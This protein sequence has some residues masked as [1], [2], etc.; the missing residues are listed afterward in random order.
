MEKNLR[1]QYDAIIIGAGAAGLFCAYQAAK[2]GL[3]VM[4]L[5][6]NQKIGRK[7]K[8]SGGG[9]CNFTNIHASAENYLCASPH[10]VKPALKNY[11]PHDFIK[12]VK[13]HN[14]DFYE[15]ELGQI[16]TTDGSQQI[17]D[18]L[19][20]LCRTLGVDMQNPMQVANVEYTDKQYCLYYYNKVSRQKYSTQTPHLVIA[21]GGLSFKKLGASGLGYEIAK[22]FGHHITPLAPA[23]VGLKLSDDFS[24]LSGISL[25]AKIQCGKMEFTHQI[26]FTHFGLSGPAILQISNYWYAGQSITID[27]LPNGSLTDIIQ[28]ARTQNPKM[29][30]VN[31]LTMH[32]PKKFVLHICTDLPF[33]QNNIA[34]LSK[35]QISLLQSRI[36]S[37]VF[38]PTATAGYD[39]AEVT[40]GGVDIIQIN[41]KSMESKIQ[42]GLFFIGEVVDVT[43]WLGGYNF[44]WAW[45][46]ATLAAMNIQGKIA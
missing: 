31:L 45:S 28:T 12:L 44:Q 41:P 20:K 11:T 21:T 33:A 36:H 10:F 26:L 29:N 35:K 15:K 8:I 19:L 22:Q 14:I 9:R 1:K 24:D 6:H 34:D 42:N 2:R 17:I 5:D 40:R 18:M 16:F 39:R 38:H 25:P 7:I 13:E 32:L 4:I 27:F 43:G 46:S 3:A 37:A 23:L 30:I